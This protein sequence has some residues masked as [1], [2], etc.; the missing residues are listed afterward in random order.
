MLVCD[1][2]G[3]RRSLEDSVMLRGKPGRVTCSRD[4]GKVLW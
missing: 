4:A 3:K 2:D 1:G